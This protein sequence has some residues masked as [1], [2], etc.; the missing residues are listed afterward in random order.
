MKVEDIKQVHLIGI[1]G[2]GVSAIARF[3]L[4][5]G[6]KVSGSDV[7][8][9]DTTKTLESQGATFHKGHNA[10]NV[11][12]DTD[13]VV[14]TPAAVDTNPE[15]AHAREEGIPTLSYPEALGFLMKDH[16]GIAVSGTNGKTTT[17]ALLGE[18]L[19]HSGK[20]PTVIL[21]GIVERWNGNVLVGKGEIFLAEGCEYR[22]HMLN[23]SPEIIVLTNI[24]E[25]HLDYYK[26]IED[27]KNAFNEYVA[28]LPR[29]GK[30]VFNADDKNISNDCVCNTSALKISFGLNE[31]VDLF[32]HSIEHEGTMQKFSL[33]WRGEEIGEFESNLIGEFN[34]YNILAAVST[35]L[36]LGV[37]SK[38]IRATLADFKAPARRLEVV[39]GKDEKVIISDYAHHPTAV[40]GTIRAV[41]DAYKGKRVLAVFQPHQKDRTIKLFDDF[42]ISFDEADEV[43]LSEIYEVSGRNEADKKISS[44]DLVEAIQKR[45]TDLKISFAKD[46]EETRKLMQ[47]KKHGVD[48][49]LVMGAGDIDTLAWK[50]KS[51]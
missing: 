47:E 33:K 3:F 2:A 26:D 8:A 11:L 21:G 46:L 51:S 31:P 22:R 42:A 13:F 16:L 12:D 24:E 10:K 36:V 28:K 32:A 4:S 39:S 41:K 7:T 14:Y 48:V 20:D 5:R 23:L 50:T 40:K 35:A 34:L 43:I 15:L 44:R 45:N 38:S 9:S 25:D 19:Q 18:V 17:T 27:I 6:V 37:S 29:D 30:L 49:V 1:G